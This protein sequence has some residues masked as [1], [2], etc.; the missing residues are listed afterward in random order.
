MVA[1][2]IDISERKKHEAK[3][4]HLAYYDALTNLPNRISLENKLSRVIDQVQTEDRA[5]AVLMLD[6]DNFKLINDSLGHGV[7]DEVL[8]Q[9]AQALTAHLDQQD[10]IAR[11]GGDE[12]IIV[13]SPFKRN[14]MQGIGR[15]EQ[16]AEK[17]KQA[18]S[19]KFN[20]NGRLLNAATSIGAVLI[21]EHGDTVDEI[22]RRVDAALYESKRAGRN[23][24]SVFEMA[25]ESQMQRR[26]E[27]EEQLRNALDKQAF[28]LYYQP[29]VSVSTGAIIGAEA[30][31]R[32]QHP[33]K[34]VI[35]PAE[36]IPI[37]EESGLIV[38]LGQW[39]LKQACQ[40]TQSWRQLGSFK[41]FERISVNV[42]SVQFND[43]NFLSV[44]EQVLAETGLPGDMLDLEITESL[45]LANTETVV[46]KM[47]QL[48]ATKVS[49]SI[50]DFGTGY[51]SLQYLKRLPV[52]TI[53]IDQ[54]FVRDM[55]T[56]PD[57]QAI[58]EAILAMAK[59]LRL[60]TVAEGVENAEY[61][62]LLQQLGCDE[63]QGYYFSRPLPAKEF[64]CLLTKP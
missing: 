24:L 63:Y 27:L 57:D 33:T 23:T 60:I 62:A 14:R 55:L 47:E 38:P 2:L 31:V 61:L 12:F 58:V 54:S 16:I 26:F 37:A 29:K 41:G 5:S 28:T 9:V 53:K 40:Q 1:Y 51:S 59:S 45:L 35:S 64:G 25:Q 36:F 18:F 34:G 30:L 13:I 46:Q 10:F 52:D 20:V 17:V 4:A 11:L 6:L 22:L 21:P 50:D 8:K 44:I 39:I 42:S 56:D 48:K 43:N 15:I 19:Q 32:W 3:I 7:G 49:F